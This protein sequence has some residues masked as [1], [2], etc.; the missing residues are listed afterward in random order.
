MLFPP[1]PSLTHLNPREPSF[2][3]ACFYRVALAKRRRGLCGGGG[4]SRLVS[5]A[6]AA[7]PAPLHFFLCGDGK[8]LALGAAGAEGVV[9]LYETATWRR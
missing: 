1:K 9:Y 7:A 6:A 3:F 5:A 4:R 2:G 8:T